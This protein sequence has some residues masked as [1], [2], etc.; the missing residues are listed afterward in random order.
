MSN[1]PDFTAYDKAMED[2]E[3]RARMERTTPLTE[4]E[5]QTMY[6]LLDELADAQDAARDAAGETPTA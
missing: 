4:E 6:A 1:Q 3:H 2:P 5:E